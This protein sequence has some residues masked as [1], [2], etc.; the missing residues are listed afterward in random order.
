MTCVKTVSEEQDTTK[1]T[2]NLWKT[3]SRRK[4][5]TKSRAGVILI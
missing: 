5:V 3:H 2:E 4:R 1:H